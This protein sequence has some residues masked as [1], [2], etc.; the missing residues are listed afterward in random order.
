MKTVFALILLGV[1][2]GVAIETYNY[3]NYVHTNAKAIAQ[4]R[5]E[6]F[7]YSAEETL[8]GMAALPPLQVQYWNDHHMP[9]IING[10][11]WGGFGGILVGSVTGYVRRRKP[12]ASK[13]IAESDPNHPGPTDQDTSPT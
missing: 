6:I 9:W 4:M 8:A 5:Y 12:T 13:R 7:G 11:T 3:H 10:S 2:I 1:V